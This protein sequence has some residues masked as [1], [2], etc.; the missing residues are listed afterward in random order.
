MNKNIITV[1]FSTIFF[2]LI[3]YTVSFF[4]IFSNFENNIKNTFKSK[5][6]LD[7]HKQ[8]SNKLHHLRDSDGR[9]EDKNNVNEY[10]FSVINQFGNNKNNI[11]IQG[12]SWSE[13]FSDHQ[14][15][16][17]LLSEFVEEN[18][19]GLIN[20]GVTS[21]SPTLMLLQYDILENEFNLKPNVVVTYIDQTDIG[22]EL[23]RYK[24]KRILNDKGKL[25][26][27]KKESFASSVYDYTKIYFV[28][29][30]EFSNKTK[31]YKSI[32]LLNFNIKYQAIRAIFRFKEIFKVGWKNRDVSK[33]RFKEIQKYLI[34]SG[35]SDTNYFEETLKNYF[36]QLLQRDYIENI[37]VMTFPHKQHL[38]E[39]VNLKKDKIVYSINVSTI[40]DKLV[41]Y[42]KK[43][44]HLNF[45]NLNKSKKITLT[46][47]MY[48]KGDPTSHLN[49]EFHAKI[50][51]KMIIH[52][53]KEISLK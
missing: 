41:K 15:S 30:L 16:F 46:K 32:L 52:Q 4:Y 10:L 17:D 29:K 31:F 36:D 13:Q 48:L 51:T 24:N 33:C 50:F 9:W 11:L 1:I 27:V 19:I 35:A 8:Y 5:E 3:V 49:E 21:Y 43:I 37:I 23:C 38:F 6:T 39:V 53:L 20:A 18:G 26:K 47:D 14:N 22:D 45:T 34:S 42:E 25:I 40:V 28:S 7:F 2:L 12:D 44:T